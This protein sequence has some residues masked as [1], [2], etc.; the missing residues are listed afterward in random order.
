SVDF[1][2]TPMWL[3]DSRHLV[4]V[5]RPGLPFGQQAQQGA[6]GVGLP[7]G[8]ALQATAPNTGRGGRG[9]QA[10]APAPT[11]PTVTNNSPGLMRATFKGSYTLAFFKA[12]VTTGDA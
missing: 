10:P 3:P 12:D 9:G 4:F 6:G 8:P 7:P 5:R 2:T 11:A 1:D